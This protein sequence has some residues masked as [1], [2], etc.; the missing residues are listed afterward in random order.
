MPRKGRNKSLSANKKG[1][2]KKR[3]DA[4]QSAKAELTA[5]E[6]TDKLE[7]TAKEPTD[8]LATLEARKEPKRSSGRKRKPT[9]KAAPL[10][11]TPTKKIQ[12]QSDLLAEAQAKVLIEKES[13]GSSNMLH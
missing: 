1:Y 12:H 6:P 2:Q 4:V 9:P 7:P 3:K 5:K 11:A 10:I 8:E 13:I